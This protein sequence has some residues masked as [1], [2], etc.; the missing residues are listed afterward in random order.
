MAG[1]DENKRG[2]FREITAPSYGYAGLSR[3]DSGRLPRKARAAPINFQGY[4]MKILKKV[5]RIASKLSVCAAGTGLGIFV[6]IV[7]YRASRAG[8]IREAGK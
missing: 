1:P 6:T 8:T 7:A 5:R 3:V 4:N 2:G